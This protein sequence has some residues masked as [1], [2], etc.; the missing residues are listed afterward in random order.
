MGQRVTAHLS[1]IRRYRRTLEAGGTPN[2][3]H[4]Q[5]VHTIL[6][7]PDWEVFPRIMYRSNGAGPVPTYLFEAAITLELQTLA[8]PASRR[9]GR[10]TSE[11][12][13]DEQ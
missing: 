11:R 1:T 9:I 7:A 10:G 13:G 12:M 2:P 3:D 8:L 5:F 4:F 6:G